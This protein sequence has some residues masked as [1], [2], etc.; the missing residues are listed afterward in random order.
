MLS[1]SGD[2]I[3]EQLCSR[4]FHASFPSMS[5]SNWITATRQ[6]C[7]PSRNP[8]LQRLAR[9]PLSI[10]HTG[11]RYPRHLAQGDEWLQLAKHSSFGMSFQH[12]ST[13]P[14]PTDE[15][16]HHPHLPVRK[17][18]PP[19]RRTSTQSSCL[20]L[21]C[22]PLQSVAHFATVALRSRHQRPIT[23]TGTRHNR[24]GPGIHLIPA[25]ICDTHELLGY[26]ATLFAG[27]PATTQKKR[28]PVIEQHE[29][30]P[31]YS[32]R[33]GDDSYIHNLKQ[34]QDDVQHARQYLHLLSDR[35]LFFGTRHLLTAKPGVSEELCSKREAPFSSLSISVSISRYLWTPA[36]SLTQDLPDSAALTLRRRCDHRPQRVPGLLQ[37]RDHPADGRTSQAADDFQECL[38]AGETPKACREAFLGD[39]DTQSL[40]TTPA[41]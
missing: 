15:V 19:S 6:G 12:S 8:P 24:A 4:M 41:P 31:E 30:I 2:G 35:P 28:Q 34:S 9:S 29:S 3:L 25:Q 1:G 11:T 40:T 22:H 17:W 27:P 23:T 10:P 33:L 5:S 14:A 37:A 13:E 21:V 16:F 32:T 38:E 7:Q 36:S 18:K 20:C 39:I 26:L